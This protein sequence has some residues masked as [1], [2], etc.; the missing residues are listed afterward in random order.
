M[1]LPNMMCFTFV[2]LQWSVAL[3]PGGGGA[4]GQ[5]SLRLSHVRTLRMADDVLCC[6]V[7]PDGKLLAVAL[8]DATIK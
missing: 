5:R 3:L 2:S 1:S 4:A 8:L 6:K 7:S